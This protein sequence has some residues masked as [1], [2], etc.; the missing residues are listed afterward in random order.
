VTTALERAWPLVDPDTGL[1][2]R[3]ALVDIDP[4]DVRAHIAISDPADLGGLYGQPLLCRGMAA[5]F[6]RDR[7]VMKAIG[8]TLERYSG[9]FYD[10]HAL[11]TATYD[12]MP[13]AATVPS[14]FALFSDA[15]YR[16]PGFPYGRITR[17]TPLRWVVGTSLSTGA[18]VAVPAGFVFVPYAFA[19]P[20]EPIFRD[21]ISTGLA[22]G[23]ERAR[24]ACSALLEV[25]ERDAFMIVWRN[26]IP[27]PAIELDSIQ[28]PATAHAVRAIRDVGLVC[29]AL[30]LTLDVAI[31]V[32]LVVL[33]D[34]TPPY[35]S[36]GLGA[37]LSPQRA[38]LHA[39][40]EAT[41]TRWGMRLA[42]NQRR[43]RPRG[44]VSAPREHGWAHAVR[45]ELRSTLDFLRAAPERVRIDEL[46]DGSTGAREADLAACVRLLAGHGFDAV[47]VDVTAPD[48]RDA[49][50]TVVRVVIPE[51]QPLDT[52][53]GF[54]HRGGRRLYDVPYALG[55]CA[56]SRTEENLNP[57][58][59]PFP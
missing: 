53:E 31:P 25:I 4:A 2:A 11:V 14:K 13:G 50:F 18:Q 17:S 58:P 21:P 54:V 49:G 5:S 27:R 45:P 16:R 43:H 3:L 34:E 55:L 1:I 56:H 7:A 38:L 57:D 33:S 12:D 40:E 35:T 59:H 42:V 37:D 48:V 9:G 8:E 41:L 29:D 52:S 24:A 51:L 47:A 32:V 20:H 39:L 6:D 30:L 28:D 46:E 22:C 26:R 44:E 15:Q 36:V 23:P 19:A 10:P